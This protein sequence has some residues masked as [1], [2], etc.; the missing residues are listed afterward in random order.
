M[1]LSIYLSSD[2]AYKIS[3]SLSSPGG[4]LVVAQIGGPGFLQEQGY[5]RN[6]GVKSLHAREHVSVPQLN[7]YY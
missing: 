3:L 4:L 7:S 6:F 5:S 2:R 1:V